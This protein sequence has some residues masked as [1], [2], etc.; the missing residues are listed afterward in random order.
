MRDPILERE[1]RD[2]FLGRPTVIEDLIII[3]FN[4]LLDSINFCSL[5]HIRQGIVRKNQNVQESAIASLM[6]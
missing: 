5:R 2:P 4:L 6:F 1:F 3:Y